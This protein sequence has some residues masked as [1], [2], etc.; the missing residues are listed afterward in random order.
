MTAAQWDPDPALRRSIASGRGPIAE[1]GLDDAL[2]SAVASGSL[3][4]VES[5]IE[6][7]GHAS[8]T[9]LA[10]DTALGSGDAPRDER[11][12]DAVESFARAAP[13]GAL[14]FVS[15]QLPVGTAARWRSRLS[16]E[17]R[18]LLL[19]HSPENL[20]LGSALRDFIEPSRVILGA[21]DAASFDR[22]AELLSRFD[23]VP[24][25]LDLTGAELAKHATNAYLATCIAFANDLAWLSLSLGVD[26]LR[27][28]EALRADPRVAPSAPL[29]PGTA[30]SGAT[31]E[32][33]VAILRSLGERFGRP[34]FFAAVMKAN[35]RH[36]RLAVT[37]LEQELGSLEGARIAVAGL[38]YKPGT[39][40]LRDSLPLRI[41]DELAGRGAAVQ[42][43]DPLAESF[44][45]PNGVTRATSLEAAVDEADALAVLTKL[46][47]L[48]EVKWHDLR[49][50]RRLVVDACVG[51][52]R[53]AAEAAGWTY[54]GLGERS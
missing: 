48:A 45:A 19:A 50:V 4:I 23:V 2:A 22:A 35:E 15:S 12:E 38:T 43:W 41:V 47:E 51:V 49:P 17:D 32:R 1:P 33:D 27:V 36:A 6:A 3:R 39:S 13:D 9:H 14:L 20:R 16:G 31:L 40:T 29:R 28:N 11:L 30:F 5:D 21:D 53:R 24:I 25:R 52:D 10:F 18:E 34:D 8:I 54:H 42:A 37:W 26:A 46:P 7:V 44:E